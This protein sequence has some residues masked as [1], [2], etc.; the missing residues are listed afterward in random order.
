MYAFFQNFNYFLHTACGFEI[1]RKHCVDTSDR[2]LNRNNLKPNIIRIDYLEECAQN[3]IKLLLFQ[4][5]SSLFKE[6]PLLNLQFIFKYDEQVNYK[7]VNF[8]LY[9]V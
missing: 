2:D 9:F 6:T 5:K 1:H 8:I 3:H 4:L 7:F